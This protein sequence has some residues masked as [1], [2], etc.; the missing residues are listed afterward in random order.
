MSNILFMGDCH[1]G[2]KN[3]VKWRPFDTEEEITNLILTNLE[4]KVTKRDITY[5]MGDVILHPD[6]LDVLEGIPGKKVLIAGNHCTER[7]PMRTLVN[8]F[9][10]VHAIMSYKEFWLSHAPIHPDELR[11]KYN[12]HGHVHTATIDDRRYI[13]TSCEAIDY[14]PISLDEIRKK[15]NDN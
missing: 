6:R 13:N 3:Q 11:G 4:K 7:I 10:D 5:F 9:D 12:I 2:H 15:I 1:F 8:I 14:S